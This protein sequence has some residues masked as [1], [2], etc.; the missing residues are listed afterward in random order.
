MSEQQEPWEGPGPHSIDVSRKG[1][2]GTG[3]VVEPP[4]MV[5][6]PEGRPE[7]SPYWVEW[8]EAQLAEKPTVAW[9][10]MYQDS[11]AQL[12]DY[13]EGA[14]V[15]ADEGDD[16]RREL[17]EAREEIAS[18]KRCLLQMQEIAKDVG[19]RLDKANAIVAAGAA[20]IERLHDEDETMCNVLNL[21]DEKIEAQAAALKLCRE[22]F[23]DHH[24]CSM[25]HCRKCLA[26]EAAK[27]VGD[28]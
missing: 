1:S 10:A 22:A 23:E 13:K 7:I 20:E 12:A 15:E 8:L 19:E 9:E 5:D 27:G 16:A 18:L 2:T 4:K 28:A 26:L 21:H 14:Q 11:Q 6:G 24:P 25:T 17:A 3:E